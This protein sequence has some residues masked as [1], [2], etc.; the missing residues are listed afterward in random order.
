MAYKRRCDNPVIILLHFRDMFN[1][2]HRPM[3][4]NQ[5]DY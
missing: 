2:E 4:F 5:N 1:N 3:S